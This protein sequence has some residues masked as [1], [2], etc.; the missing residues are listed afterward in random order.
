MSSK[1]K[2]YDKYP[3][4]KVDIDYS[5][6]AIKSKMNATMQVL[7]SHIIK[8]TDPEEPDYYE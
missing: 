3:K 5:F 2:R 4:P 7:P 8:F 6:S 1:S